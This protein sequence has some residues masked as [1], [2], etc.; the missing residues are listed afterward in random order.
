MMRRFICIWA[1]A[2]VGCGLVGHAQEESAIRP[3]DESNG[4]RSAL[5]PDMSEHVSAK[6]VQQTPPVITPNFSPIVPAAHQPA[7]ALSGRIVYMNSGHGWTYETN[8]TTP[9]W[10]LQRGAALNSMNEDYG[11]W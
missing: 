5:T 9:Y 11:N 3:E 10:R 2:L 8:A 6:T 1:T 7:G 4:W